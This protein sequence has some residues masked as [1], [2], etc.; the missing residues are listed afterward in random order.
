MILDPILS[1]FSFFI[2]TILLHSKNINAE[3]KNRRE[4]LI[5]DWRASPRHKKGE[6]KLLS[7]YLQC[8]IQSVQPVQAGTVGRNRSIASSY[9][10][11]L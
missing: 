7:W 4:N 2:S 1:A 9:Q 5:G 6:I 3:K 11:F 10:P 8:S